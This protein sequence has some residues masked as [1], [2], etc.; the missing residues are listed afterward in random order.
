[1]RDGRKLE[2]G[3]QGHDRAGRV[4]RAAADFDLTPASLAAQ[5]D[6]HALVGKKFDPAAAVLGLVA[7]AI[8]ADD[9]GTSEATG[10][11]RTMLGLSTM[12]S[13]TTRCS[14]RARNTA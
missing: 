2:P 7:P 12:N 14:N 5:S 6:E 11:P 4:G 1:M 10:K 8:Q 13:S 9:L 3:L